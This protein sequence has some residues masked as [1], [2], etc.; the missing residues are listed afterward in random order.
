VPEPQLIENLTAWAGKEGAPA[1]GAFFL[2]QKNMQLCVHFDM[3]R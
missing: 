3:D 2:H 1:G